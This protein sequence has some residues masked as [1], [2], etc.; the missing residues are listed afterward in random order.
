MARYTQES[1]EKVRDAVDFAE[2]V[3]AKTELKRAG[4]NRLQGLCP[5]HEERT[6][7]FGIDPVEKLY[8]CFGCGAGGDVFSF[9]METEGLDFAGALEWLAD[10]SGVELE[11]ESEDPRD[12][13][14][15]AARGAPVRAARAHRRL[16]RARAVGER[17][18]R[19]RAR[20][21]ARPRARRGRAARAPR[22]LL[23]LAL[24]PGAGGLALGGLHGGG[25]AGDRARAAL[26]RGRAGC[27]TA[28]AGRIMFPLADL[29]GRVLGFGARAMSPDAQPKYLNTSEGD[30]LP[31]GPDRLRR[32]P[33]PRPGG[34]GRAR[35]ARRGL[36]GRRSR[37]AR[38]ACPR[39]SAR[40][41]RR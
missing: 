28:S 26:A 17:R 40:W 41:A 7:S 38:R 23:A 29:K 24:G 18:G 8:H 35:G 20:V 4:Q 10:R 37:C 31:Q 34:A 11:R 19:R 9:V 27:S 36:H 5:F 13:P 16:L 1:R 15:R 39:P 14:K 3:G 33:R 30:G 6:P 21:P 2:L 12:A 25:A 32:R 22:R